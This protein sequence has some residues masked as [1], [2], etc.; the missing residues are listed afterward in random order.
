MFTVQLSPE[1]DGWL[2]ALK[3]R[4]AQLRIANR[5]QRAEAG[6]L[7]DWKPITGSISEMRINT[8]P[9]YRLYF[10]RRDSLL[11]VMLAG[12]SKSTQA[13]DIKRAQAFLTQLDE[14]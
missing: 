7:G 3:D 8:G 6:N 2:D 4:T 10:T 14:S 9:G 11:I 5:L 12:G 13:R 1:F